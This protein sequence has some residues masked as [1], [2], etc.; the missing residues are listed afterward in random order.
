MHGIGGRGRGRGGEVDIGRGSIAASSHI[1]L[2]FHPIDLIIAKCQGMV[3]GLSP[4]CG[5]HLS[6]P[7]IPFPLAEAG[8]RLHS[9]FD[10]CKGEGENKQAFFSP[11]DTTTTPSPRRPRLLFRSAAVV[12]VVVVVVVVAAVVVVQPLVRRC[13]RACAAR[14]PPPS[15]PQRQAVSCGFGIASSRKT[16]QNEREKRSIKK[17]S[18]QGRSLIREQG[19]RMRKRGRCGYGL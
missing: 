1:S 7:S 13:R 10:I 16:E 3:T 12:V 5:D 15:S 6:P 19:R 8:R 18:S 11:R 17:S 14:P 2:A 4:R 9:G